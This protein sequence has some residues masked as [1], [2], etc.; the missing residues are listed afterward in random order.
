MVRGRALQS[1]KGRFADRSYL[2]P[3]PYRNATGSFSGYW[4]TLSVKYAAA[5]ESFIYLSNYLCATG[6]VDGMYSPL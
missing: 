3:I 2:G 6:V 1:G 4:D 5:H